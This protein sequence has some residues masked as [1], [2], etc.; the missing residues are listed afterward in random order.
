MAAKRAKVAG[1]VEVLR[2]AIAGSDMSRS[3]ISKLSGVTPPII[4]RFMSGQRDLRLAT[5]AKI[6]D[7]LNLELVSRK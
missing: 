6:A 5:A 3:A 1:L 2:G 4:S 7:A